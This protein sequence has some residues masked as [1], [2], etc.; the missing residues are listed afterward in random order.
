MDTKSVLV[1]LHFRPNEDINRILDQN[2][3]MRFLENNIGRR[4]RDIGRTVILK[5]EFVDHESKQ[6]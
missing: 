6:K 3:L 1:S 2:N 5:A 4:L